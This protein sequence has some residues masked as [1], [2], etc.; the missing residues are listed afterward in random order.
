MVNYFIGPLAL[1]GVLRMENGMQAIVDEGMNALVV[2]RSGEWSRLTACLNHPP[3]K[4]INPRPAGGAC[5]VYQSNYGG[6][7]LGGDS[8]RMRVECRPGSRLYLG[9]QSSTKVYKSPAGKVSSQE[10]FGTLH[11]GA[12]AV[13]C[14]D[15]VVPFQGSRYRQA[16]TWE[17]HPE[18]DL[19]LLDWIQSGREARGEV[20]A[21]HG[22]ESELRLARPGG[23][24][25]LVERFGCRPGEEEERGPSA[26]GQFG[27]FRSWLSVYL[28]GDKASALG[29]VLC[30][31]LLALG[32]AV[33]PT[34]DATAPREA[35]D[36]R[37][38]W[39][40][41]GKREGLGWV[42]RALGRDRRDVQPVHDRLFQA[43][44]DPAWLG[45]NPWERRW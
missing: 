28:A 45:F 11:A 3:L 27:P 10:T 2:E 9:T 43:L 6:G 44:A 30:P 36:G 37:R 33:I 25:L 8:I 32:A 20:F 5:Q 41:V 4:F 22:F 23:R 24:P 16:Q 18:S 7:L 21:F 17:L 39:V 14:P 13:V 38:L 15:P 40:A 1:A 42:I 29:D 19:V 12:L 35:D 26:C 31:A 34:A